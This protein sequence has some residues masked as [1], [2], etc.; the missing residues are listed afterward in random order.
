M[1]PHAEV[2]ARRYELESE[3]SFAAGEGERKGR[4]FF[5]RKGRTMTTENQLHLVQ[6]ELL[7]KKKQ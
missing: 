1:Q 4:T 6:G 7:L 3:G 5:Q 2:M